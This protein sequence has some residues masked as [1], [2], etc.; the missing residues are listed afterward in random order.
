MAADPA[1]DF[2]KSSPGSSSDLR[3]LI[4][5]RKLMDFKKWRKER[6]KKRKKR[7]K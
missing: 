2:R 1:N 5:L 7:K 3:I 4:D 6:K